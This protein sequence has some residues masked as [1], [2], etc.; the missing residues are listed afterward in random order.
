MTAT[1]HV[2]IVVVGDPGVGKTSLIL[3]AATEAF[4]DNPVPTLP[5]TA[6]P[7]E[8]TPDGVPSLVVDTS[9]RPEDRPAL[10][11]QCLKADVVLLLWSKDSSESLQRLSDYW[12]PELRRMGVTVPIILVGARQDLGPEQEKQSLQQVI[13]PLM[14]QFKE[15]EACLECSAKRL[16]FVEDVFY[17]ALKAVIHPTG[18]LFDTHTS[19]LKPACIKAL[20]RI[21][22]LCDIDGDRI[23]NDAELNNFQVHC[24]KTPLKPSELD[25]IKKVVSEKMPRGVQGGGLTLAGFLFLHSLF[26]ERGRLETTWTV[27]RSYGY[28]DT[29]RLRDDL[30]E[31][32][33]FSVAADQVIELTERGREFLSLCFQKYDSDQDGTL[34][35]AEQEDMFSTAPCSPWEG[36]EWEHVLVET[37]H[38]GGLTRPGFLAKWAY[39]TMKDPRLTLAHV[40]YLGYKGDPALLFATSRRRKQERKSE[41]PGRGIL[42]CY[43]FGATGSG[44]TGLLHGL[45]G[46]PHSDVESGVHTCAV[47]VGEVNGHEPRRTLV[48]QEVT[49]E[50][51]ERLLAGGAGREERAQWLAAADVGLFLFDSSAA[52]SFAYAHELMLQVATASGDSLPCM[53]AASKDD[54]GMSQELV[55][56]CKECCA[57]LAMPLPIPVSMHAGETSSVYARVAEAATAPARFI[58]ETPSLKAMRQYQQTLRRCL[59]YAG[60]GV[61]GGALCYTLYHRFCKRKDS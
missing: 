24:W 54:I 47:A 17:Y 50:M 26:I 37:A 38:A 48:M 40:L 41:H 13:A 42:Q 10:E 27:L 36:A 34:S 18:P 8:L 57:E 49:E 14:L 21:F 52:E 19:Q 29:L 51:A 60:A 7:A 45:V 15:V 61:A 43:V 20:K 2:N 11:I 28:N 31:C 58:P 4:P 22:M 12:L 16:Q 5:P 1:R 56:R 32:V 3:A 46:L 39:T 55:E 30:L 35:A 25:G 53:F 33:N 6:L 59:I 9:S 44:K 23:L